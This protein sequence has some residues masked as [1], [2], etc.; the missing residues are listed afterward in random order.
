[1]LPVGD[2]K[3]VPQSVPGDMLA[4]ILDQATTPLGRFVIA[5]VAVHAVPGNDIRTV[6]TTDLSLARGTL[7]I[8][9]GLLRHTV[10]L[11]EFSHRLATEWL[12]YRDLRWPASTSSHLLVSQKTALDDPDHP[13]VSIGMI[14]GA[15]ARGL[16]LDGLRQDRILNEAFETADPLQANAT[17]RY[18]GE[19]RHTLRHRRPPG[20]HHEAAPI[21]GTL[22]RTWT[23]PRR[24][25]TRYPRAPARRGPSRRAPPFCWVDD[26]RVTWRFVSLGRQVVVVLR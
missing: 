8:R 5:L 24:Q 21:A 4:G 15:L 18:H 10:Y 25:R 6:L 2:L 1:M 19:D 16:T 20:A 22:A 9:R 26:V 7:E 17:V 11:E 23:Q 13:A 14:R 3:G 12:T